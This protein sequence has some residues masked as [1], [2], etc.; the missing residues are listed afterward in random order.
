[1]NIIFNFK[2]IIG[3]YE[4][5]FIPIK[6]YKLNEEIIEKY[7][8]IFTEKG[9]VIDIKKDNSIEFEFDLKDIKKK[10]LVFAIGLYNNNQ[11]LF[12]NTIIL[13]II[14]LENFIE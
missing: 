14:N 12:V 10:F 5:K 7:S 13:F 1:M 4:W 3:N 6:N 9:S 11:I 2:L 8:L